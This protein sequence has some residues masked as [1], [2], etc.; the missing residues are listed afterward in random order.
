MRAESSKNVEDTHERKLKQRSLCNVTYAYLYESISKK[1]G[2]IVFF[3]LCLVR[4]EGKLHLGWLH[5]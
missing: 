4:S 5:R 2:P 1:I 3:L